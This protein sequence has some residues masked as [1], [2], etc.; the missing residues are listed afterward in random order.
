MRQIVPFVFQVN[1]NATVG[2]LTHFAIAQLIDLTKVEN[3]SAIKFSDE[4]SFTYVTT[5][6]NHTSSRHFMFERSELAASL[7]FFCILTKCA[8]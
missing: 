3:V 7:I 4:L 1:A 6:R 5:K 2:Y 8:Q